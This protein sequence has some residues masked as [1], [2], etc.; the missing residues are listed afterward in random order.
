[1]ESNSQQEVSNIKI[2]LEFFDEHTNKFSSVQKFEK[3]LDE[4]EELCEALDNV[5]LPDKE[6]KDNI[7]DEC[8]DILTVTYH[9]ATR[10]GY[11]G[12]PND[13]FIQAFQK[14]K[15][16]IDSGERDYNGQKIENITKKPEG[17]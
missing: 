12:T 14:M 9:I 1:M 17:T 11:K 2:A 10:Y 8:S 5:N 15:N 3:I 6:Y 4:A 13:L 16:R 7:I